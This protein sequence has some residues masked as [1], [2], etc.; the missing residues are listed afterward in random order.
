MSTGRTW[1]AKDIVR[2][3]RLASLEVVL[4]DISVS[5]RHAEIRPV[6]QGWQ[7]VD[8]GSTNGTYL[9]GV[10]LDA[11]P[12]QFGINDVLQ[13]GKVAF[14]VEMPEEFWLR[15]NDPSALSRFIRGSISERKLRLWACACVQAIFNSYLDWGG[16][17][18][19]F[20]TYWDLRSR[21]ERFWGYTLEEAY[22]IADQREIPQKWVASR[23]EFSRSL[24]SMAIHD[25]SDHLPEHWIDDR[26]ASRLSA[27]SFDLHDAVEVSRMVANPFRQFPSVARLAIHA[28]CLRDIC[29]NPFRPVTLDPSWR[30]STVVALAQAIYQE[31][32]FDQM[33]ILADALQDAD[34]DNEDILNHCRQPG[35]HC[36]GCWVLDLTLGK[37]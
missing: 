37:T 18:T 17:K 4:D 28:N 5:R 23:R 33:P 8:C 19:P 13:F 27:R 15:S 10:R 24:G 35:E 36:R 20:A 34:C 2:V 22:C 21:Y 11:Q 30:T 6:E 14:A 29:G 31:N 26:V 3:G 25:G 9:N 32:A 12:R 7:V 16:P 1:T